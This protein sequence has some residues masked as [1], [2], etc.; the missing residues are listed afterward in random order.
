MTFFIINEADFPE[1][2]MAVATKV[3]P[4]ASILAKT[5]TSDFFS[6]AVFSGVGLLFSLAVLILDQISPGEWF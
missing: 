2:D 4:H 3:L 5:Q 1:G 6:I